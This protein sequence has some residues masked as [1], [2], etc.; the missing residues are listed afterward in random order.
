[1]AAA[2]WEIAA[3]ARYRFDI[4]DVEQTERRPD[5]KARVA[6]IDE[7]RAKQAQPPL[8]HVQVR[9]RPLGYSHVHLAVCFTDHC[10]MT[11]AGLVGIREM[12][13]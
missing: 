1:M 4:D 6:R 9:F 5:R 10:A 13:V 7:A 3:L 12:L 11:M 8:H 2:S